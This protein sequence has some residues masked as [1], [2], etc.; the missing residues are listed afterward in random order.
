MQNYASLIQRITSLLHWV[1]LCSKKNDWLYC[2][3]FVLIM[4]LSYFYL[5]RFTDW[6]LDGN[7]NNI[8]LQFCD[9]TGMIRIVCITFATR[10]RQTKIAFGGEMYFKFYEPVSGSVHS[11]VT[12]SILSYIYLILIDSRAN[13]YRVR[14]AHC[15]M[16]I[17]RGAIY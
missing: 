3:F 12:P 10:A 17:Y 2:Y 16:S 13:T 5:D 11:Q 8:F 6:R 9:S 1:I 15:E 4:A 14:G 7:R